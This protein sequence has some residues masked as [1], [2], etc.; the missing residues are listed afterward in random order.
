LIEARKKEARASNDTTMATDWHFLSVRLSV[1]PSVRPSVVA[2]KKSSGS[3][4]PNNAPPRV[5]KANA[6]TPKM[7]E[8][9]INKPVTGGF[10]RAL[11]RR[12]ERGGR[13]KEEAARRRDERARGNRTVPRRFFGKTRA[14]GAKGA[15]VRLAV[16][17]RVSRRVIFQHGYFRAT[18]A[19]TGREN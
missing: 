8:V 13:T 19:T 5:W 12:E 17:A 3:V 11:P 15:S 10:R 4:R 1:R 14:K 9:T 18:A 16:R 7:Q 6:V 2:L